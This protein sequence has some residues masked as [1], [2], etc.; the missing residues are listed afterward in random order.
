MVACSLLEGAQKEWQLPVGVLKSPQKGGLMWVGKEQQRGGTQRAASPREV[1]AGPHREQVLGEKAGWLPQ[2]R[3]AALGE[4]TC[5]LPAEKGMK[6]SLFLKV[7]FL[8]KKCSG[9]NSCGFG[10][11]LLLYSTELR[12]GKIVVPCSKT[13]RAEGKG[14]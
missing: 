1:V 14:R 11:S 5:V 8:F 12:T 7:P 9:L 4:E 13:R 6:S 3:T 10:N 2:G